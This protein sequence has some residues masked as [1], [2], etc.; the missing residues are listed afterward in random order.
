MQAQRIAS[1]PPYVELCGARMLAGT[2]DQAAEIPA[3]HVVSLHGARLDSLL[4][5]HVELDEARGHLEAL[6]FEVE[7]EGEDGLSVTVPV[8]R[9]YDVTREADVV[10]EVARL[11]GLDRLPRTLPAHGDRFGGLTREQALRRRA[12]ARSRAWAST[13]SWPGTSSPAT[14]PQR[15]GSTPGWCRPETPSPPS[16]RE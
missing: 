5:T 9:H 6:E 11:H 8:D 2:I 1:A 3:P 7:P 13:R 16:T 12:E 15:L 14:W 10:E 4:G